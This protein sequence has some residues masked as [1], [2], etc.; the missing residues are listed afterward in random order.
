V[1]GEKASEPRATGGALR[2]F[3]CAQAVVLLLAFA[4]Y[5]PALRGQLLWD[6]NAH[7]TRADLQP[8]AGLARIWTDVRAT[9]QYYPLLHSAFWVEHRLW[10]DA[11]LGYH[12]VNILAHGLAAGLLMRILQRLAVPGWWLAGVLFAVHPVCVETVAWISEQKNTLSLVL[13]LLS[14]L[15]Y[16]RFD[17]RRGRPGAAGAYALAL[18]LFAMALLTKSVTS[19][20]PAALLVVTWWRRGRVEAK[21]DV[22]P[23]VPWFAL[24]VAGGLFTGWVERRIVG[25]EGA[26]FDLSLPERLLLASRVIWFYLGKILWPAR[27]SFVYPR[28]NV[29]AAAPGWGLYLAAVILVT[30]ALWHLR[31]RTRGPL[32]AWLF[33]AGS[34]FP[35]LGF[36]NV[37]PFLFS[38]VAD[39]FQYLPCIGIFAGAS[40]CLALLIGRLS[41]APRVL[42]WG[43]VL[44]A[45]AGLAALSRAQSRTY[46]DPLALY[47]ATLARNP[48]AWLA[49]NNRGAW[50]QAHGH[51][52]RA[53]ADY[54]AAIA[55]NPDYADAHNNLGSV[56]LRIPGSNDEAATEFREAIRLK[57]DLADAHDNLGVALAGTPRGLTGAV[58]EYQEAIRLSPGFAQA[59]NNLG[60][61]WMRV[62]GRL[63]DAV[64]EYGEALRLDPGNA[65]AHNNLG[66]ALS[67]EGRKAEAVE[68]YRR[69]LQLMP[70]Y[71]SVHF[72]IAMALLNVPGRR[73]EATDELREFLKLSPGNATAQR[74]LAQIQ[75]APGG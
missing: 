22:A 17:N 8:V 68:Q 18:G 54:T 49:Y 15:A 48:E 39:H 71:S 27:L 2:V 3:L 69:A 13:Y 5:W 53:V 28:W 7:V 63:S 57:P 38:Y 66:N 46:A 36:F 31:R 14:A 16:L 55:L 25:A 37:F 41:A 44:A 60:N 50:H 73:G 35:A 24:A 47:S 58:A 64:L 30:T 33:F 4:C 43:G 19:T 42:C 45:V 65:D 67:A 72:N 29:P 34:L 1:P 23:L 10:G 52:D 6:D 56:L 70:A 11:T 12:I 21:R 51:L 74:I 40:A 61:A 59:H 20:L 26:A 62:P 9:Q 32:A 75:A